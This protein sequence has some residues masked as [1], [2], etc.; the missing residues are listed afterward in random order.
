M[1]LAKVDT[2]TGNAVVQDEDTAL[3]EY[4]HMALDEDPTVSSLRRGLNKNDDRRMVAIR[5]RKE[6]NRPHTV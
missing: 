5:G 3:A 6:H 2:P 4:R 1:H